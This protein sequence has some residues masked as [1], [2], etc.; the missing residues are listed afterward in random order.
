MIGLFKTL[1]KGQVK[2]NRS[3]NFIIPVALLVMLFLVGQRY[4]LDD[5]KYLFLPFS[6]SRMNCEECQKTGIVRDKDNQ[7]IKKMCPSCFGVGYHIFRRF[8]ERDAIC[9]ACGGM[10]RTDIDGEWGLCERCDGRGIFRM[11]EWREFVEIDDVDLQREF[12][13]VEPSEPEAYH[14]EP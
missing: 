7:Q 14:D 3:N 1:T 6:T 2:K 11:N 4:W 8:D 13:K 12:D 10:G 9:P 5:N